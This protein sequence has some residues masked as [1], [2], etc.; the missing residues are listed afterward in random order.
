[1][2]SS[3]HD[4]AGLQHDLDALRLV[5][6]R[7]REG[8]GGRVGGERLAAS[9]ASTKPRTEDL[10]LHAV[11]AL[12]RLWLLVQDEATHE[13]SAHDGNSGLVGLE[14]RGLGLHSVSV[15]KL[16]G[17]WCMWISRVAYSSVRPAYAIADFRIG[18]H[19]HTPMRSDSGA[20]PRGILG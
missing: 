16:L 11:V 18:C 5:A 2:K 3:P 1:M 6:C 15:L 10:E 13:R 17:V 4:L 20:T 7:A 19:E 9:R 8:M 12:L 14:R